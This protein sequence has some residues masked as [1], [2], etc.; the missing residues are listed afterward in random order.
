MPESLASATVELTVTHGKEKVQ[1]SFVLQTTLREMK[2]WLEEKT[3]VPLLEQLLIINGP[4]EKAYRRSKGQDSL[5]CTF[6]TM[7]SPSL[8]EKLRS[9]TTPQCI[10]VNA[11]MIGTPQT[12]MQRRQVQLSSEVSSVLPRVVATTLENDGR[13]FRC[14]FG[15][16][17]QRQVAHVCRTCVEEG[18]ADPD[19]AVC[20]ACAEVCHGNHKV[21][22]WGVRHHMRC[23]CCTSKCWKKIDE[24]STVHLP[25]ETGGCAVISRENVESRTKR[26]RSRSRSPIKSPIRPD[27]GPLIGI[28]LTPVVNTPSPFGIHDPPEN[29]KAAVTAPIASRPAVASSAPPP[30]VP[31]LADLIGIEEDAVP[32]PPLLPRGVVTSSSPTSG[33]T[34]PNVVPQLEFSACRF[35]LDKLTLTPPK[36]IIP[37]NLHNRYPRT[38]LTWCYCREEDASE[39]PTEGGEEESGGLVCML[40]TTC[41]WNTHITAIHSEQFRGVPCYGDILQGETVVFK[42]NTCDTYCCAPCRHRC[43]KD[44]EVEEKALLSSELPDKPEEEATNGKNPGG[45]QP[46]RTGFSTVSTPNLE[47]DISASGTLFTCGCRGLCSIAENISPQ[48]QEDPYSFLPF[49]R[50]TASSLMN[51]DIFTGF[52]CAFCMQ[53]YPWLMTEDLKRCFGGTLPPKSNQILPFLPCKKQPGEE[54]TAGCFPYHGMILPITAFAEESI[55]SCSKCSEA[56]ATF[57]PRSSKEASNMIMNLCDQCDVCNESIRDKPAFMCKTCEMSM[58]DAFMLCTECNEH[59]TKM[60]EA[61]LRTVAPIDRNATEGSTPPPPA[62]VVADPTFTNSKGVEVKYEHDLS[63]EFLEDTIDNV[64]SLCGLQLVNSLEEETRA[65]VQEH[66]EEMQDLNPVITV[67]DNFGPVPIEFTQEEL[68]EIAKANSNPAGVKSTSSE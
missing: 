11:M 9:A 15:G 63:H 35:V 25:S 4:I 38:P 17:Y 21:E 16:G 1:S 27:G 59:R 7:L 51:N 47:G 62:Q 18:R 43:H 20:F 64:Y 44:H 5:D 52:V 40:C 41:F 22:E 34:G 57:A 65:Y 49:S 56:F 36:L 30:S 14:S 68:K 19:H 29:E 67:Q 8:L 66:W 3:S 55:C 53:E 32:G 33:S 50:E 61:S 23:D 48:E 2:S 28:R 37:P 42:C 31:L 24:G 13:W 12:Q 58:T 26:K 46:A 39:S 45:A 60:V 6:E 10:K 54:G